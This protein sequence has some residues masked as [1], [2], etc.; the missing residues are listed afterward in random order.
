[1]FSRPAQ[2]WIAEPRGT[3]VRR[4]ASNTIRF[5][6]EDLLPPIIRDTALFRMFAG[7]MFKGVGDAA[8][9][10]KRAAFLSE[11]EYLAFYQE[12]RGP[13]DETDNSARCLNRIAKDVVGESVCDV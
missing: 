13:H 6:L 7:A 11:Q 5:V 8:K 3:G 9:F 4:E 10:R 2:H 12:W 1:M